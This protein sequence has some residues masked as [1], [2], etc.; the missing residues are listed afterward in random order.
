MV[1]SEFWKEKKVFLTGHTGFKGSWL[2]IWLNSMGAVVKGYA[3]KPATNPNL[4]TIAGIEALVESDINDIRDY[5]LLCT[6]ILRFSPDI[7]FHMAAQPLVRA[8][9]AKP[10]ETYETNVMGTANLLEAVRQC[11][12]VKAVVNITTDKC[13]E[14]NEW[15]WGYKET[16]RMGGRDPYSS[17][18]GCSEL[19]TT[20]YRES[21]L[22]GSN[23]GVATARAG[24]V[25]GGGDWAEDRLI[26]DILRAFEVYNPVVIRNPHATRPWQHV[27]EPLSGYLVLAEQLFK[28]PGEF[29]EA[30]NFGPYERDI[31]PVGSILDQMTNLWPGTSWRLDQDDNPHEA[32]L[33]KLDISKA[34]TILGWIPTWD[35]TNTLGKIIRWH[36]CWVEG[37][38]MRVE[39]INEINEFTKDMR[40]ANN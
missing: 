19:V 25:I 13:Y 12:S 34:L 15:V 39:C 31:Q 2:S 5:A 24:N 32:M 4:F 21:F 37:S 14:N 30:W 18:K 3:L 22:K 27:L 26:P 23:I 20:S 28:N 40:H 9:Y 1:N 10:L 7:V 38:N 36:K 8:S 6:S 17:S 33:L 35:L 16:D 11:P 29:S